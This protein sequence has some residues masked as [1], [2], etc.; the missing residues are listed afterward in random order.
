[1]KKGLTILVILG[2]AL[3]S[4]GFAAYTVDGGLSDWGVTPFVDWVPNPPAVYTQTDNVNLYQAKGYGEEF[5]FEAMY[6]DNNAT[7]LYLGVVSSHPL[8]PLMGV[9]DIGIDLNQDMT[10]STHGV[11]TGLE[12]ALLVGAD[13]VGQV[14]RDP[15]WSLTTAYEWPDGWQGSPFRALGGTVVGSGSV[16]VQYYPG[17]ESG[18]YI[19]EAA[20][21]WSILGGFHPGNLVG[22]HMANWCGNDSINLTATVIPAPGALVLGS[23]GVGLVGWLRRRR[24][25]IGGR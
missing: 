12:Y 6:Y 3:A 21:P 23:L 25:Q 20:V 18:T 19:L 8:V 11:V 16:A 5:D 10:I 7:T 24:G 15:V 1:M 4:P 9:G 22:I 17:M 2:W 14:R 13:N